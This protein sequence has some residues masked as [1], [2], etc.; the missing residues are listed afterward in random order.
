M[1][2]AARYIFIKPS[3]AELLE[4]RLKE[5][6]TPTETVEAVLKRLPDELETAVAGG[7]YDTVIVGD[8]VE[9]AYKS[10]RSFIYGALANGTATATN[11]EEAP[12]EAE[13][14]KDEPMPDASG[15]ADSTAK[16]ANGV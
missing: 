14:D 15:N 12:E 4:T 6:N 11:G 1:E 5:Q 13:G 7:F 9:E 10:L 2:Y 8:S 16:E 3:S